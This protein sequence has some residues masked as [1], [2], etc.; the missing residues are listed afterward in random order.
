VHTANR[1]LYGSGERDGEQRRTKL[2][3]NKTIM[4]ALELLRL[5]KRRVLGQSDGD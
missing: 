5:V 1:H 3:F 4:Q 2:S